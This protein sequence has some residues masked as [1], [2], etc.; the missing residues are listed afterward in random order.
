L[1]RAQTK[2]ETLVQK[3][4]TYKKIGLAERLPSKREA[5]SLN[6]NTVPPK[7][8]TNLQTKNIAFYSFPDYEY[9]AYTYI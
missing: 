3:Y 9:T 2:S 4:L 8:K 1:R 7:N 6:T 5:L